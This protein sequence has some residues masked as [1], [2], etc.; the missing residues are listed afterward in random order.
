MDGMNLRLTKSQLIAVISVSS[1]FM[2]K[3]EDSC[4]SSSSSDESEFSSDEEEIET[5]TLYAI[6][7]V[8]NTRGVNIPK[9][10][11]TDYVERVVPNYSRQQFKEH[12]R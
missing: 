7:M 2:I 11:L 6:L 9:E 10:R 12:F 4:Y 3:E 1:S 5:S 8:G